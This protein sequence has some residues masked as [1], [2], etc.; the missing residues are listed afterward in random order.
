MRWGEQSYYIS[1]F[2]SETL[3]S[4]S[5]KVCTGTCTTTCSYQYMSHLTKNEIQLHIFIKV[6]QALNHKVS[7]PDF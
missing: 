2:Y 6:Y 3:V 5:Y 4:F 7:L 1:I